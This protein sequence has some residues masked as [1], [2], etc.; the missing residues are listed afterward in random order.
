MTADQDQEFTIE[1]PPR[2]FY[3]F[4]VV[5]D[6]PVARNLL[7]SI[8]Q[9]NGYT[10]IDEADSGAKALD[11]LGA[12]DYHLVL[13]DKNMPG[14]DGLEVMKRARGARC[15]AEFVM[16]TAYGS[17]ETAMEA[18][19]LGAFSYVTKPFSDVSVIVKRVD[20]ALEKVIIRRENQILLERLQ[21]VLSDLE[22][23]EAELE[24]L[25][26]APP[27]PAES[28]QPEAPAERIH[29]AVQR[30]R[31]LAVQLDGLRERAKGTA[32]AIVGKMEREI[33]SVADM[34]DD[35]PAGDQGKAGQS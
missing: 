29:Q 3:R 28:G 1:R 22:S 33:S 21:R 9:A 17:M 31:R 11:A 4:L 2:D 32:A 35:R 26:Q 24:R 8:L 7:R 15:E 19:D 23:A 27:G 20:A 18:M 6:E 34:L 12:A 13:L 25:R 10:T 5:D 30:L 14:M 16:I